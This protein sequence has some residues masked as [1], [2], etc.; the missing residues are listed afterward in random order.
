MQDHP[1]PVCHQ[2][3]PQPSLRTSG[4]FR[5]KGGCKR[6]N[7][8]APRS[9]RLR[10]KTT[11]SAEGRTPRALC[12]VGRARNPALIPSMVRPSVRGQARLKDQGRW[13]PEPNV[14]SYL[15]TVRGA[16]RGIIT[17][18]PIARTRRAAAYHAQLR[19]RIR[20]RRL[21]PAA[22]GGPSVQNQAAGCSQ[23]L[24]TLGSPYVL[25]ERES[26]VSAS[27]VVLET[28]LL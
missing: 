8:R 22:A 14:F 7:P 9:L 1:L 11:R 18:A 21:S 3:I 2:N 25:S 24:I 16:G 12:S 19:W 17:V 13:R 23:F 27:P 6:P 10:R 15:D 28:R 20:T 5:T 26:A 4:R